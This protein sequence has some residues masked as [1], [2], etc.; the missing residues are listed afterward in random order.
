[1]SGLQTQS[2]H[3]GRKVDPSTGA[4][5][6]PL[7]TSTT[8][9]RDVDGEF[10]RKY[11]Y[12]R[13]STPNR[14]SLEACIT[15][16]EGGDETISFSSGMAAS[17]AVFQSLAPKDHVLL[18]RD[19]Y[20]GV[21]ELMQGFFAKWG[22][23]HTLVDMRDIEE[24]KKAIRPETKLFWVE[25]PTN[26]LIEVVD[27]R[28]VAEAARSAGALLVCENTF[29]TPVLQRPFE[30]GSDMV[31][32]SLTKYL[33]GHSDAMGGSVTVK[34]KPDLIAQIRDFQHTG[35]A[36]LSP[37]DCWLVLRGVQTLVPRV[38]L[39]CENARRVAEFL[40][41]HKNV[42]KVRYPGLP[43]DPGHPIAKAQMKDF[44]GMLAFEV[45]GGRAEAFAV[46]GALKII[47][48]ATSLGGTHSL[49][50]HRASIEGPTTRAPESLLRLSVGLE[51]ADDLIQDLDQA[52]SVL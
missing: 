23:T 44:G 50:E 34:N 24:V 52:L 51:D 26:P 40:S 9:E 35:G 46:T 12:I 49:I 19:V 6:P 33:G 30:L 21:R 39:H 22:L 2:I 28:T 48:R 20:Y 27:I 1:M 11:A 29:A 37:F 45:R 3:A 32:H 15:A 13:A 31:V 10:S 43:N 41:T 47:L 36:V 42:T 5:T 14:D 4:V 17:L 38:R 18:H 16:L 8:F 7:H 25:T